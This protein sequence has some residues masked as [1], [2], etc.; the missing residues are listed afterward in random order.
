MFT[1]INLQ[2]AGA[3]LKT[4]R[5]KPILELFQPKELSM[6]KI[7]PHHHSSWH[8]PIDLLARNFSDLL[9]EPPYHCA[10]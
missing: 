8:L 10:L 2:L 3:Q 5:M 6:S 1:Q 7:I 4:N 9:L